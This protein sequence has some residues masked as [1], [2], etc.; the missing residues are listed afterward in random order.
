MLRTQGGAY[1]DVV[2]H[3]PDGTHGHAPLGIRLSQVVH[4]GTDHRSQ[5][6]TALTILGIE[7]P[8]IDVWDYGETLGV[9]FDT[10]QDP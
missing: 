7:P 9:V 8:A 2:A 10:P 3:R 4:H 1:S 6:C 5:V